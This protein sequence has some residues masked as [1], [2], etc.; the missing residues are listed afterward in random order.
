MLD[1]LRPKGAL[2]IRVVPVPMALVL[3]RLAVVTNKQN[4]RG[5]KIDRKVDRLVSAELAICDAVLSP[6]KSI[7]VRLAFDP[8]EVGVF[9]FRRLASSDTQSSETIG[10]LVMPIPPLAVAGV[11]NISPRR[12]LIGVVNGDDMALLLFMCF[13]DKI[14]LPLT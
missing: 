2:A 12:D 5:A 1:P 13:S 11:Q 3:D 9:I 8:C 4:P 6:R 7:S 10:F 14:D